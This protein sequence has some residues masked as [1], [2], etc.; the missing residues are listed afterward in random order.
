MLTEIIDKVLLL[1]FI[2]SILNILKHIFY[3][4]PYLKAGVKYQMTSQETL[5]VGLS[6]SYIIVVLIKGI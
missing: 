1:L 6:L 2:L 5:L 3:L 4:V